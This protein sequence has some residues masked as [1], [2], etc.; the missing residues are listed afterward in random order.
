[1]DTALQ[2]GVV[3]AKLVHSETDQALEK[4]HLSHREQPGLDAPGSPDQR[5]CEKGGIP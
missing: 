4:G 2:A 3:L 5:R 1:M